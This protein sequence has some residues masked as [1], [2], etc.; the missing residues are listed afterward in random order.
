MNALISSRKGANKKKYVLLL[1]V[2]PKA[3]NELI[4][5]GKVIGFYD[6]PIKQISFFFL[7][8]S[9]H[10]EDKLFPQLKS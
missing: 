8:H 1:Q 10:V 2:A 9:V 6:C 7:F 3:M 4:A 5:L